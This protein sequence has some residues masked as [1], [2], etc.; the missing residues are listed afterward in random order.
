[1]SIDATKKQPTTGFAC[2]G[3][4]VGIESMPFSN[5]RRLGTDSLLHA[6]AYRT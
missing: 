2:L 4:Q 6:Q 3:R 5:L 1:M